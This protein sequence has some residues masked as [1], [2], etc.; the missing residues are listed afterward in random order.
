MIHEIFPHQLNNQFIGKENIEDDDFVFQYSGNSLLLEIKGDDFE[1]P[2]KKDISGFLNTT[3]STFL[4]SLNGVSCFLL[5]DESKTD[6][7]RFTYKEISFFRTFEQQEIGWAGIVGFQLMNWYSQNR[8]CGKCGSK[9]T[10]KTDERAIVCQ[11]CNTIVYPKISPAIIVAILC[12]GKILL[13]HNSGFRNNMYSLIAG[14]ADVGETLEETVVREVR[15]EVGLEVKNIRYYK[16]QPWPFTGSMMVG[17][18]AEAESN[19]TI[20]VDNNEITDAAWYQ[21]GSLPD[22]A[23]SISIG[24][25]MIEKFERGVL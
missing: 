19:Q 16:S 25:E 2:R 8:Y 6:N 17:F 20:C 14:F 22:H 3:E 18:I 23:P 5:W 11:T 15:E 7:S 21:R 10:E 1:I 4:F 12:D 24:G 13:A 9:T